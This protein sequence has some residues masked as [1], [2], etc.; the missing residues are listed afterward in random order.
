MKHIFI[1]PLWLW[2]FWLA[3]AVWCASDAQDSAWDVLNKGLADGNPAKRAQAVTAL[4]SIG[5][6]ERTVSLIESGLNDKDTGVRETA[7]VVL[8]QIHARQSIPRLKQALDDESQEVNFTAA[9][10]LWE[11]GDYSGRDIFRDVLA[12]ERKTSDGAVKQGIRDAKKKLHNPGSLVIMGLNEGAGALLG[13]FSLGVGFA[14]DL[15]KDKGATAR[16]LSAK[17][18]GGDPDPQSVKDL[19]EALDD[20]NSVVRAAAARALAERGSRDSIPVLANLLADKNDGVRYM[21]AAAIIRLNQP[22]ALK[23]ARRNKKI[24]P[25][26]PRPSA[27]PAPLK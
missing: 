21:S 15:L 19:T 23:S 18:L 20:K 7:A 5:T 14:E 16:A 4:G 24:R 22:S 6:E 2:L 25:A 8:G 11:L 12:G 26:S 13:P 10:A 27:P 1:W 17:L 9:K 3:P